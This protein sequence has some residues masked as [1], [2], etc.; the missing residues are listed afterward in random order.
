M[1]TGEIIGVEALI[2]WQHPIRGFLAPKDFLPMIEN[3][4]LIVKL[5]DWV[6]HETLTQLQLWKT[7]DI[8]LDASVNIA[9]LQLQQINFIA[10]LKSLLNN[11]PDIS[12]SQLELEILETAAIED[13]QLVNNRLKECKQLGINVAIDDF[14]TGY[15]SLTYLKYLS[16]QTIKIDQRLVRDILLD[17]NDM[18]IVEGILQLAKAFNRIAL[19]EGVETDKHGSLL[20]MIGCELGQGYAIAR[21]MPAKE[22][23]NWINTYKIPAEWQHIEHV[24]L[25]NTDVS[26]CVLAVEHYRFVAAILNAIENKVPTL[27]PA[28]CHDH[29]L[30][31]LGQWLSDSGVKLYGQSAE[32][33]EIADEHRKVHK[34]SGELITLLNDG[35]LNNIEPIKS[36]LIEHRNHVLAYLKKLQSTSLS[37]K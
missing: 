32:F 18:A 13:L 8:T 17:Q 24:K 2:R 6:L 12:A 9:A 5:G 25:A 1:R 20:L 37:L 10:K 31:N 35:K 28:D 7:Q 30:C 23:P 3:H 22:I 36:E 19:A 26:L 15:S 4:P 33:K 21:P 29:T 11:Y 27:L 16:A 34:M 14:G